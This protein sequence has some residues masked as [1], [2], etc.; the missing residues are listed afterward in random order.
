MSIGRR[1]KTR[2]LELGLSVDDVAQR[3]HKSRATVYRYE[4]GEIENLPM[5]LLTPLAEILQTTP[6]ALAGWMHEP[7]KRSAIF[8]PLQHESLDYPLVTSI[9]REHGDFVVKE[10]PVRYDVEEEARGSIC[11][12]Y[13]PQS[14]MQFVVGENGMYPQIVKGD[15][16]V[17]Y[18][19]SEVSDGDLALLSLDGAAIIIRRIRFNGGDVEL[20]PCNP[21]YESKRMKAAQLSRQVVYGKVVCLVRKY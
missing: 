9:R 13:A 18:C 7:P 17:F 15:T 3:L 4:N 8:S 2:R 5:S 10:E 14:C 1:I 6:T 21:E 19:T 12:P 11:E 16:V 20:Q